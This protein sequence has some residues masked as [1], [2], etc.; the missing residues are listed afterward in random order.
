MRNYK[1]FGIIAFA[2]LSIAFFTQCTKIYHN[3]IIELPS[4]YLNAEKDTTTYPS[5]PVRVNFMVV[6][7]NM[8]L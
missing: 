5:A 3:S 8:L 7:E 6:I 2:F 4:Y 1:L